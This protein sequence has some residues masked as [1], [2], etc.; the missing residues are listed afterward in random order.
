MSVVEN[1]TLTKVL[2]TVMTYP[3]PSS[4]YNELVCTAG[5]TEKGEWV[6][7]YPVDYRYRPRNQQFHK[8]QWIEVELGQ[9]GNGN[10]DRSESHRPKLDTIRILGEPLSTKRG[11]AERRFIID[12]LPHASINKLR[13]LYD[14]QK[15][16]LGIVRPSRVLDLLVERA[17]AEWKPEWQRLFDETRLFG[18]P[19]KPLRKIPYK[20]SYV[21]E[22]ADTEAG[23]PHMAMCEDWEMGVLFLSEAARLGS[24]EQ[25]AASVK[26]KFFDEMCGPHK[27]TR[28]FV[29]T[30]FPWNS[31]L[32]LGLFWP[33][34]EPQETLFPC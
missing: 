5:I 31:W 3:H 7:L 27:D 6:R 12:A 14:Q 24:D 32:V 19:Q 1:Y 28:F 13:N 10:D 25:A 29:G 33:P 17:D 20:F 23:N 4:G 16:S 11:W 2:I 30:V 18:E 9:R 21:F 15:V 26:R 22:C 8:Y 34:K